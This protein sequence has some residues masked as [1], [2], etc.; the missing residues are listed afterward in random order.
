MTMLRDTME[1]LEVLTAPTDAHLRDTMEGLEVLTAPTDAK[2]RET[3]EGLEVLTVVNHSNAL[4][5]R[6]Q[7]IG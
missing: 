3:M 1:G 4:G 7:I 6:A 5:C 2:F